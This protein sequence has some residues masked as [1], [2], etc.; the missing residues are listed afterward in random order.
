MARH[1]ILQTFYASRPWREFRRILILERG[2]RC[3]HC[4]L[5][6]DYPKDL[7]AHHE[8]ELTLDNVNDV[9]ISMNPKLIKLVHHHCH[10]EIHGRFGFIRERRVYLV[11]GP[12]LAGKRRL[13][14]SK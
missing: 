10:N 8:V 12:P 13:C 2:M 5:M 7:T 11:Y 9:T 6:A 1:S 4:G 14:P 3:E